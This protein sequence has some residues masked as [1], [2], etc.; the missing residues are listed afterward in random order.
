VATGGEETVHVRHL[1]A[2]AAC[3]GSGAKSGTRPR[4]CEQCGGT[5]QEVKSQRKGGVTVQQITT[6]PGCGGRGTIIDQPCPECGGEGR[7][8]REEALRVRIS[9]G[10]EEGMALRIP[11][12][13]LPSGKAGAPPGDLFVIVRTAPDPHFRRDGA[14]LW[15]DEVIN[16]VD[17]VVGTKV[18]VPTLEGEVE[19]T[20]PPSTQPETTVRVAGRGLP[21]FGGTGRGD[22]LIGLHVHVP[23]RLSARER[24]LYESLRTSS[25]EDRKRG[26]RA[27]ER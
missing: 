25:S 20:V 14:D 4:P 2:C 27:G 9:E 11:G 18:R 10:A 7:A 12:R 8:W 17:A 26:A 19:V 1:A 15:R 13:G 3:N 23:E 22:L 5:G 21:R 16:V 6:C 24:E